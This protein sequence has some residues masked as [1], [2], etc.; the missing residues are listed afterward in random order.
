MDLSSCALR[1][2]LEED[3]AAH[4]HVPSGP[5]SGPLL[6]GSSAPMDPQPGE[7]PAATPGASGGEKPVLR[8]HLC[9][10]PAHPRL[11]SP[12]VLCSHFP[13]FLTQRLAAGCRGLSVRAW[14]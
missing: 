8:Q 5:Y 13:F 6:S 2:S 12:P 4:R 7:V 3:W 11:P 9:P 10:A 14:L 1:S